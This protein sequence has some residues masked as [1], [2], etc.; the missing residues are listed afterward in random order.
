MDQVKK[1]EESIDTFLSRYPTLFM[2]ARLQ[3][4]E[5]QYGYSK[6]YLFLAVVL[7]AGSVLFALGGAKLLSDLVGFLYPAYASFKAIDSSD[8]NDDTQWLTYWVIFAIF[9][10]LESTLSF[11]VTWIP[12]YFLIKLAFLVWLYHPTTSGAVVVYSSV[13]RPYV[14]PVL[15]EGEKKD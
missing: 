15:G 11:L 3:S 9:N 10:L 7:S 8:P 1:L 5:E 12:F 2:Y 4:L 6:V 13:V 14:L